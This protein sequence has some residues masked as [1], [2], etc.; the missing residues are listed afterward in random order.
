CII[1]ILLSTSEL[2]AQSQR[3]IK[4]GS[5]AES[6]QQYSNAIKHF[7]K[8][9]RKHPQNFQGYFHRRPMSHIQN[10]ISG[11]ISDYTLAVEKTETEK[12]SIYFNRALVKLDLEDYKGAIEDNSLALKVKS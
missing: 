11:A 6:E 3:Y 1:V 9:I 10:D 7:T 4:K 2:F 5:K 12:N 8:A